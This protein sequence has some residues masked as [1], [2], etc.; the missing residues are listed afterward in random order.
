M[1]ASL[2]LFLL[3][4]QDVIEP[5]TEVAF[6]S[7]AVFSGSKKELQLLGTGVR[8]KTMFAVKVY[9]LGVYVEPLAASKALAKWQGI[10]PKKLRQ[11]DNFFAAL[12]A[13]KFSKTLRWVFV[14]DVDGEA[15]AEAFEDQLEPRLKKMAKVAHATAKNEKQVAVAKVAQKNAQNGLMALKGY[16]TEELEEGQEI[17]FVWH[18]DGSLIILSNGKILGTITSG[19]L[20]HALF[21]TTLGEDPVSESAKENM[22]DGLPAIFATAA[23]A[24][25]K[26][27]LSP[28]A[29]RR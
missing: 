22:A 13:G 3:P 17:L 23:E 2:A 15:I 12:L 28:N 9:A 5:R 25:D 27:A 14:R 11:D 7:H 16:F 10:K 6:A 21:D 20:A 8:T 29:S 26:N 18:P 4:V 24:R 19:V 1:L